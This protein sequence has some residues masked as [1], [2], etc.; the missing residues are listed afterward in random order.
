[1]AKYKVGQELYKVWWEDEE[2]TCGQDLYIVRSIRKGR[3]H[4]TKKDSHTWV[5]VSK[6]NGDYGW[7]SYISRWDKES[8]RE[9]GLYGRK[10]SVHTT[11]LAAWKAAKKDVEE[12]EYFMEFEN[13]VA[14]KA[15]LLRTMTSQITKN[16]PTKRGWYHLEKR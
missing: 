14:M 16:K 1:M 3:I 13:G 8:F 11:K 10:P 7:A 6:K 2:G 12:Y 9:D 5:K 15:K 4:A